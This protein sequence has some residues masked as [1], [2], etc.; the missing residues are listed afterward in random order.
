M[1]LCHDRL[2]GLP[3]WYQVLMALAAALAVAGLWLTCL[4]DPGTIPAALEPGTAGHAASCRLSHEGSAA[5]QLLLNVLPTGV[6]P[7]ALQQGSKLHEVVV[8]L[9]YRAADAVFQQLEA[10]VAVPDQHLYSRDGR[11]VWMRRSGQ[12]RSAMYS[13][14]CT[15]CNIWYACWAILHASVC[16]PARCPGQC[17]ATW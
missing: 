3:W 2:R 6:L 17:S 11:G 16:K 4:A 8:L 1:P 14:Y 15:T 13:K 12:G 7:A 5:G 10:G 9:C